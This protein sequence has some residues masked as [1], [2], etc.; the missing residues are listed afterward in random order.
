MNIY[1]VYTITSNVIWGLLP[2]FWLLLTQISPLYILATRIVW[3]ALFCFILIVLKHLQPGL[4]AVL[5]MR[6]QWLAI[7]GACILVTANWGFFIYAVTQGFILQSGLAY[8]I[9]PIVVILA[10]A[11]IYRERLGKLQLASIAF[12]AAGLALSFFLYGQ[13]PWLSLAICLTFSGYSL[14]KKKIALDS[15]VSVFI[16]AMAMVPLSLAY[17]ALSEWNGTGAIDILHGWQYLLLPATG[18]VTATPMLFFTAGLKGSPITVSGICMYLSPVMTTIIGLLHGETLTAPL[19]VTFGFTLI[20]VM[21]Y[22]L[23]LFQMSRRWSHTPPA[24]P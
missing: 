5:H 4:R 7:A 15:Q 13:I 2:L 8:F 10:G 14:L 18:I 24:R 3:S 9:N 22:I 23:G 20:A 6:E 1:I 16:E 11:I 19:A 12:A 21:F 17:I